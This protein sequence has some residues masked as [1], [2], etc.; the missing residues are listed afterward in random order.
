[1]E[2]LFGVQLTTLAVV[3]VV[4]LVVAA[5]TLGLLAVRNRIFFKL[6]V[7]NLTRRRGRSAI[8]VLGLMLATAIIAAALSTGD[9]MASTIRSTVFRT[10]GHTDEVVGVRSSDNGG[11]MYEESVRATY[12]PASAFP[13]VATA[14]R[15]T[16]LV[17]GVAPA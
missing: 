1:M 5:A 9:T 2:R 15:D 7:R 3:L 10:L 8:I 14:A 13:G 12:F 4:V 6:G 11:A 16:Q 17:D